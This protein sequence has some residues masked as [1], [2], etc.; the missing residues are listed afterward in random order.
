[1]SMSCAPHRCCSCVMRRFCFLLPARCSNSVDSKCD[2]VLRILLEVQQALSLATTSS[3]PSSQLLMSDVHCAITARSVSIEALHSPVDTSVWACRSRLSV[4]DDIICLDKA[5][6]SRATA[7]HQPEH[8][9]PTCEKKNE[10][11]QDNI[12]VDTVLQNLPSTLL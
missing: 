10:G 9:H 12:Y 5:H 1:M 7:K 3:P 6:A 2:A 11:A 8:S 4:M